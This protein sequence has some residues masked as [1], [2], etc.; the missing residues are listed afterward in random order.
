MNWCATLRYASRALGL[1]KRALT[2]AMQSVRACGTSL[3]HHEGC[4]FQ[5]SAEFS[6][7][8]HTCP[9]KCAWSARLGV[10]L[11][12]SE[13]WRKTS[14]FFL[15]AYG[16]APGNAVCR[17]AGRATK[18]TTTRRL[19]ARAGRHPVRRGGSL[20]FVHCRPGTTA[21]SRDGEGAVGHTASCSRTLPDSV[22]LLAGR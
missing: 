8:R 18:A 19:A 17:A 1:Q 15:G 7:A 3:T 22:L 14:N 13:A 5:G 6:S 9:G 12:R 11:T 4:V 2:H 16:G 21:L 10:C 20:R